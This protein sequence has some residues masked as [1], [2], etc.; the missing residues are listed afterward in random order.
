LR[1]EK[2]FQRICAHGHVGLVTPLRDFPAVLA[3]HG[4]AHSAPQN[5][6]FRAKE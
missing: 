6:A 4:M 3:M 2:R 1:Q 5:D